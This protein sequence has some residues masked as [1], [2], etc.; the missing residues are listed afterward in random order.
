MRIALVGAGTV[1]VAT[2]RIVI[3]EGHDVI[4]VERDRDRIAALEE[5]L[6]CGFIHGDGSKPAILREVGPEETDVLICLSDNDQDNILA[7]LVGRTLGFGRVVTKIADSELLPICNELGLEDTI[8]P[9]FTTARRLADM[10]EGRDS[11]DLSGMLR[12]E[13]RLFRF[14]ARE[15]DAVAASELG[16]PKRSRAIFLYRDDA[17]MPVEGDTKLKKGDEVVL[18]TTRDALDALHDRWGGDRTGARDRPPPGVEDG[19]DRSGG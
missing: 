16:L 11:V 19:G 18:L 5:E 13:V 14:F 1:A 12:G 8:I 10:I 3:E 2:A 6:D 15:E 7:S 9:T 17:F 4:I